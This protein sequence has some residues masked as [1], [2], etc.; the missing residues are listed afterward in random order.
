M[1]AKSDIARLDDLIK[2]I[3]QWKFTTELYQGIAGYVVGSAYCLK[4]ALIFGW[5]KDT[6]AEPF[7][8]VCAALLKGEPE[9]TQRWLAG[10]YYN[11]AIWRLHAIYNVIKGTRFTDGMKIDRDN[12]AHH[13]DKIVANGFETTLQDA[14]DCLHTI[15]VL[16][17]HRLSRKLGKL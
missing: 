5:D 7:Q 1:N 8:D 4:Q 16:L 10:F 12:L 6:S 13:V 3:S 15:V 14:L 2:R 17:E 9:L 11:S